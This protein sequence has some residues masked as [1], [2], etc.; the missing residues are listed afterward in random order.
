MNDWMKFLM[1]WRKDHPNE[2]LKESMQN[3]KG[4]YRKM[5][6]KT[7]PTKRK[8]SPTKRK[9]S[10]TKRKTSP[11][12]RMNVSRGTHDP[13]SSGISPREAK[14]RE[15][16]EKRRND[17]RL[18]NKVLNKEAIAEAAEGKETRESNSADL[19]KANI[20]ANDLKNLQHRGRRVINL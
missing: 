15:E 2:S 1:K 16:E 14:R 3:A 19:E 5:K 17:Q 8:T 4:P 11:K 6:G 20:S 13:G 12:K 18:L 9:T 10:P 7:S